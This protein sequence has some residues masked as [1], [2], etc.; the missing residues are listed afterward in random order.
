MRDRGDCEL[1]KHH[2]Y[3]ARSGAGAVSRVVELVCM[4]GDDLDI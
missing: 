1:G 2:R 4:Q 3:G